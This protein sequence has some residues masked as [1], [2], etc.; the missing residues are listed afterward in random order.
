MSVYTSQITKDI[1]KLRNLSDSFNSSNTDK[2]PRLFTTKTGRAH[3]FLTKHLCP[4]FVMFIDFAECSFVCSSSGHTHV[5][6]SVWPTSQRFRGNL[7]YMF[8]QKLIHRIS[9]NRLLLGRHYVGIVCH[10]ILKRHAIR[11][12]SVYRDTSTTAVFRAAQLWDL[13]DLPLVRIFLVAFCSFTTKHMI[14]QIF[15]WIFLGL[16]TFADGGLCLVP[17]FTG[18]H[19]HCLSLKFASVERTSAAALVT[20]NTLRFCNWPW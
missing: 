7:P 11:V 8:F 9:S 20:R 14:Q 4:R 10:I 17:T 5:L 6:L 19:S 13:F 18:E 16:S 12:C 15:T 3:Y 1:K 2:T